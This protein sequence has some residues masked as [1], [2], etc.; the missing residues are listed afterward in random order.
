MSLKSLKIVQNASHYCKSLNF[1]EYA[2]KGNRKLYK[3]LYKFLKKRSQFPH[4]HNGQSAP[5]PS[6]DE[7]LFTAKRTQ[8]CMSRQ[9][10]SRFNQVFS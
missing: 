3:S 5:A 6:G 1:S 10:I 4:C 7:K 9:K 2:F 8:F